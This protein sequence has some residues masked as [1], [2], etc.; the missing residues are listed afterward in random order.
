TRQRA[1]EDLTNPSQLLEVVCAG[2]NPNGASVPSRQKSSKRQADEGPIT[3]AVVPQPSPIGLRSTQTGAYPQRGY[4][5]RAPS[6]S[7]RGR[8]KLPQRLSVT[9]G[10]LGSPLRQCQ[11]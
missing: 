8:Q 3:F 4:A 6:D 11:F 10:V 5:Q 1:N 7:A 9:N 2:Q